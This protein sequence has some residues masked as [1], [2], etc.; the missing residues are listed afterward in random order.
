MT[1]ER[2]DVDLAVEPMRPDASLG[3]LFSE[4]TQNLGTLLRQEVELAKTEAKGQATAAGNAAAMLVVGA[5]AAVLALAFLSAG[6]AWLLDNVMGSALAFAL[7]GAA[8]VVIAA[9]LV[10]VGRHRLS[11]I[12]TLPETKQSIKEDVEWAKAQKS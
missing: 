2:S 8:W 3:E 12:K 5:V 11:E 4:M 9:V 10:A 7:V 1:I 6:L